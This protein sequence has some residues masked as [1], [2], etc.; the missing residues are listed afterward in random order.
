M[1][2]IPSESTPFVHEGNGFFVVFAFMI[3]AVVM[4]FL[5]SRR[6]NWL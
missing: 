1:F 2:S 6:R 3:S 4:A 5:F